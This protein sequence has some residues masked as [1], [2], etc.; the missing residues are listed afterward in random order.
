MTTEPVVRSVAEQGA[1]AIH[2]AFGAY[3]SRFEEITRRAR[4]RFARRDWPVRRRDA[5]ERLDLYGEVMAA[6]VKTL[7]TLLGPSLDDRATWARMRGAYTGLVRAR[8]DREL[9]ETFFNSATRQV[10]TTVG[11][12]PTIEY[13]D[14][15][16]DHAKTAERAEDIR[17]FPNNGDTRQLVVELLDAL[18]LGAP[19]AD[20][21]RD[22]DAV[23][24]RIDAVYGREEWSAIEVLRA[25]FYRNRGCYVVGRLRIA[26]GV[27]P[28]GLALVHGDD[29]VEVDAA[30]LTEEELSI[31]FSFTR[32]YFHVDAPLPSSTIAFL[33]TILPRKPIAELYTALGFNKHGKTEFF[34]DLMR[35]VGHSGDQ[36]ELAE[37]DRGMV[38][39][40]FGMPSFDFVFKVIRDRFAYP[41][42]A[43]RR[44]VT[45]RYR[46]VFRHD[47]A[48]RLVEAQ[49]FEYLTFPRHLFSEAVLAELETA[50]DSISYQGES[51][52]I[53]HLYVERRVR[54]LNLYLREVDED[55]ARRAVLDYG[56][57]IADL[58]ATNIFPGDL[59]LKNFGVTRHGRVVFYDYDELCQI[60][61]CRFRDL[62]APRTAD[63][64]M[65]AE[66]WFYV[67]P[68]DIFPE[69]FLSFL[70]LPRPLERTFVDGH[71]RLATPT[72]WRELQQRHDAGEIL[73]FYPYRAESRL[74]PYGAGQ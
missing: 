74:R 14:L 72:F 64:E 41:K 63:E 6:L 48:G 47:R 22:A 71:R 57:A 43:T 16:F 61:D 66:P 3:S 35:H 42:T 5:L 21:R 19:F 45:D 29:G 7:A 69:E 37:G 27:R 28:L 20:R 12:D 68:H 56:Q 60:T 24:R 8:P 11:V 49:E 54:P 70:G 17:V 36:F 33:H 25:P 58:A 2:R 39:V 9:A 18:D 23:A 62:P 30:I 32:S 38:M 53:R 50:R 51:V 46:M 15:H 59:L 67:G 10:F 34:R 52:A 55:E 40:V 31:V 1:D 13:V 65:A 44:D 26:H 4:G 73:E